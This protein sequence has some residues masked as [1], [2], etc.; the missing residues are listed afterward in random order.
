MTFMISQSLV[1]FL[2]TKAANGIITN[3]Y[4]KY[5]LK[6]T[7]G[8]EHLASFGFSASETEAIKNL[9]SVPRKYSDIFVRLMRMRPSCAW[10]PARWN[11]GSV[12]R[13]PMISYGSSG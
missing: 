1:D 3:A 8:H 12:R 5:V 9:S 11:T 2:Q 4:I 6:L 13:M 7:K 10:S